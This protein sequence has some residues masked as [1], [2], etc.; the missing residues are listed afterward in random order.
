[1]RWEC[2]LMRDVLCKRCMCNGSECRSGAGGKEG[3]LLAA[4][5]QERSLKAFW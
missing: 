5:V 1:M 4:V 2:A 3:C